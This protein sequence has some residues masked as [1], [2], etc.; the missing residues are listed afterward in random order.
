MHG[1]YKKN[2]CDV[3]CKHLAGQVKFQTTGQTRPIEKISRI[4]LVIET[5]SM[6]AELDR[7][8]T[9]SPVPQQ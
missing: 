4:L 2:P 8:V 3:A 9:T 7:E 1:L 6:P 5:D